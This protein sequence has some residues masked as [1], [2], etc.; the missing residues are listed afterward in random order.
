MTRALL[1]AVALALA[2]GCNPTVSGTLVDG[3]TGQPIAGKAADAGEDVQAL[4]IVAEAVKADEAGALTP[5]TDAGMTCMNKGSE[6]GQDG[7]FAISDI[8]LGATAYR[9]TLS[10]KNI[11]LGDIDFFEQKMDAKAPVTIKAWHA[12]NGNGLNVLDGDDLTPVRSRAKVRKETIKATADELVYY[13]ESLPKTTPM[14]SAGQYLVVSG[15]TY[16]DFKMAPVINNPA[17][18]FKVEEGMESGPKMQAWSYIGTRFTDDTTYE[19]VATQIDDSKVITVEKRG[20]VVKFIPPEAVS[21]QG[22]TAFWKEGSD[23][24]FIVDIGKAGTDPTPE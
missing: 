16:A 23:S 2:T 4:R 22:R 5:N 11:F 3:I 20:H 9:V 14:V 7:S 24:A 19:R 8:C 21:P 18:E 15:S 1:P 17:L 10:D 12:P 13:P 6:V